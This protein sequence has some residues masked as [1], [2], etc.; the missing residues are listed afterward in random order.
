MNIIKKHPSSLRCYLHNY[1][2]TKMG[3]KKAFSGV[4]TVSQEA[5]CTVYQEL[6]FPGKDA[7]S[8]GS[9]TPFPHCPCWG[10]LVDKKT[11]WAHI[12]TWFFPNHVTFREFQ[13]LLSVLTWTQWR[14]HLRECL[15][16]TQKI[17]VG[18]SVLLLAESKPLLTEM[19]LCCWGCFC[20]RVMFI[21]V[22]DWK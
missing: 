14:W 12:F 19:W 5:K 20:L 10:S 15:D 21:Y 2:H 6:D 18:H 1:T 13:I 16:H 9:G 17:S 8:E 11:V 7:L 4:H 22:D 3:L